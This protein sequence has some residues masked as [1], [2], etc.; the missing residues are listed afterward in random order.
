MN[1]TRCLTLGAVAAAAALIL[2][3]DTEAY[4]A[5]E[6]A[7]ARGGAQASTTPEMRSEAGVSVYRGPARAISHAAP[8]SPPPALVTMSGE[9]AWLFDSERGRLTGCEVIGSSVAGRN[10]IR[11]A[12]RTL[13]RPRITLD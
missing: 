7:V 2:A 1:K 12:S 3:P 8:E 13:R 10:A 11:C 9:I 5:T 6:V 4:S